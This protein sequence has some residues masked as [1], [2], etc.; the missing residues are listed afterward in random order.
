M[1]NISSI[2]ILLLAVLPACTTVERGIET[3]RD[4]PALARGAIQLSA[5]EVLDRSSD[6]DRAR[7]RIKQVTDAAL[8]TLATDGMVTLA[9]LD[10]VVESELSALGLTPQ[11]RVLADTLIDVISARIERRINDGSINPDDAVHLRQVFVWVR[12][13]VEQPDEQPPEQQADEPTD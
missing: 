11:Q 1:K 8:A 3:A 4:N 2:F 13:A 5:L 9:A 12:D 7:E 6:P 10:R